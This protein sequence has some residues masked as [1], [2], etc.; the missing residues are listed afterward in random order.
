MSRSDP[1]ATRATPTE[2]M[3]DTSLATFQLALIRPAQD[4]RQATRRLATRPPRLPRRMELHHQR[5]ISSEVSPLGLLHHR[6]P[7][8]VCHSLDRIAHSCVTSVELTSAH[9]FMNFV[10]LLECRHGP[11][12]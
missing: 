5:S 4:H 1:R 3:E 10:D 9:H 7:D 12:V 2:A 8:P 11:A 6:V